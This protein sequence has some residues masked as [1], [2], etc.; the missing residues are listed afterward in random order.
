MQ[1]LDKCLYFL[2]CRLFSLN[3]DFT[4][5]YEELQPRFFIFPHMI[6]KSTARFFL[7]LTQLF[8]L[9][10]LLLHRL[11]NRFQHLDAREIFGISFYDRP[12][13]IGSRGPHQHLIDCLLVCVPFFTVAPVFVRD[14]PLFCRSLH[15]LLKAAFLLIFINMNPEFHDH[16]AKIRHVLFHLIDFL[17]RPFPVR[18]TAEALDPLHHHA[19]VPGAVEDGNVTVFGQS[20]PEAPEVMTRLFVRFRAGDWMALKAT[21]IKGFCD[22][23]ETGWTQVDVVGSLIDYKECGAFER[24]QLVF[25]SKIGPM[26]IMGIFP[27][28]FLYP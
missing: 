12:R 5:S 3:I 15:A 17:I 4:V 23:A 8:Y 24:S 7:S 14:F 13:G 2:N 27:V 18:L 21:G 16:R 20:G 9:T 10:D 11:H 26:V 19:P 28:L 6:A 22:L 25:I 1:S